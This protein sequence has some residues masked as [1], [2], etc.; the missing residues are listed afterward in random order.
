MI[1]ASDQSVRFRFGFGVVG[2]GIKQ[3]VGLP[4]D[5]FL[6]EIEGDTR[7]NS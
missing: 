3:K 2:E 5:K 4:A 6:D 7:C 1:E